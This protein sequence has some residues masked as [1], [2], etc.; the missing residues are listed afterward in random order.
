MS[1]V[2]S[3]ELWWWLLFSML[4]KGIVVHQ[5][6]LRSKCNGAPARQPGRDEGMGSFSFC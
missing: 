2:V 3:A 6:F 1:L 5:V 4:D